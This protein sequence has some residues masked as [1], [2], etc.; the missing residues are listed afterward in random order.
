MCIYA[1]WKLERDS[2]QYEGLSEDE[3]QKIKSWKWL[4]K[5]KGRGGLIS[6]VLSVFYLNIEL[7]LLIILLLQIGSKVKLYNF[8][9]N[10][11]LMF[12]LL[13]PKTARKNIQLF[14]IFIEMYD[15]LSYV[16]GV[17]I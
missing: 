3:I 14:L 8:I 1:G 10:L 16:Y 5:L 15:L 6:V 13:Y 7:V 17:A 2:L 9:L 4:E 12:A 11:Y